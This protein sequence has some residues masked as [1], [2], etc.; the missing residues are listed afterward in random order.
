MPVSFESSAA[1]RQRLER[2][3]Q[4]PS[5]SMPAP[6]ASAPPAP[7]PSTSTP[8]PSTPRADASAVSGGRA[9]FAAQATGMQ[10]RVQPL[11]VDNATR[12]ARDPRLDDV[13]NGSHVLRR[14]DNDDAVVALQEALNHTGA[15]LDA[16]GDFGPATERA[17]RAFQETHGLRTDGKVGRA[18]MAALD[19]AVRAAAPTEPAPVTPAEPV[20]PVTPTEPAP[21]T[22]TNPLSQA[23]PQGY[24]YLIGLDFS[25]GAAALQAANARGAAILDGVGASAA[26]LTQLKDQG[27]RPLAYNNAF[28]TQPGETL[29]PGVGVL[30]RDDQW[31]EI[32]PDFKS[33]TWQDRRIGE[34]KAAASAGFDGLMIDNVPRAGTSRD[35]AEYMKRMVVEARAA[36]GN[37]GFGLVL[38]NGHDLVEA[39]PWLVDEGYVQA[40][41]KEDVT[42]RV[43]GA[44]TGTGVRVSAEERQ[45][46]AGQFGRL[47]ERH[48]ALP[49]ISVDYPKNAAQAEEARQ[50]AARLGFNSSHQAVGDGTLSRISRETRWVNDL[51]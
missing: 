11:V 14:G 36:S 49:L 2:Q 26:T 23:L 15:G 50:N 47:R 1:L 18:T 29:P 27:V 21:S 22:S 51:P 34:A 37:E 24:Q 17:V 20:A 33:R 46:I 12:A 44:G 7:T 25:D 42:F 35:A 5:T 4:V 9:R 41:Q 30:A 31:G 43:N 8:P 13:R 16:D 6:A 19:E 10:V 40:L 45:Q 38:Q 28:Q 39:H 48:P 32:V 3:L